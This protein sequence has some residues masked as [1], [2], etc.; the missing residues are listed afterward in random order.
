MT[1]DA[2]YKVQNSRDENSCKS[3]V[4]VDIYLK[5]LLVKS[6]PVVFLIIAKDQFLI[7][8]LQRGKYLLVVIYS[9]SSLLSKD[10][11]A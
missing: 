5:L 2:E 3:N 4:R 8:N 6:N 11:H 10:I 7:L 1:H 9:L